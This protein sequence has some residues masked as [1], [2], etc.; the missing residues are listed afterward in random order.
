MNANDNFEKQK[1]ESSSIEDI[2]NIDNFSLDFSIPVNN[3]SKR[4][5]FEK[6]KTY[7][8]NVSIESERNYNAVYFKSNIVKFSKYIIKK[9]SKRRYI[10]TALLGICIAIITVFLT[11]NSGLYSAGFSGLFQGIARFVQ[12]IMFKTGSNPTNINLVYNLMF[13]GLYFVAN[14]PL[15]IFSYKKIS[16]EFT[17]LTLIYI[18]FN[19]ITGFTFN[20]I[21]HIGEVF[22][23]GD[24]TG[25][26]TNSMFSIKL[27]L[28][29]GFQPFLLL[30]YSIVGAICISLPYTL[31]YIFSGSTGGSDIISIYYAKKKNKNIGSM[32]IIVN[33]VCILLATILG[34]FGAQAIYD[35]N[36][37]VGV[38]ADIS[39]STASSHIIQALFSPNLI[40]SIINTIIV[41]TVVNYFFPR[42]KFVQVKVFAPN[43]QEMKQ[44]IIDAGYKH[45]IYINQSTNAM[46][47]ENFEIIETICMYI[48]LPNLLVMIRN[49]DKTSIISINRLS[50]IDGELLVLK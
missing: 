14:I 8:N 1:Y 23:F 3:Q 9:N 41:G 49:I 43:V 4:N 40:F 12:A 44:K 16:K 46:S 2:S 45:D 32:L 47:N 10:Y 36:G 15:F 34:S 39:N 17:Y 27:T 37:I 25:I 33:L 31:I 18:V 38:S 30:I 24:T 26:T 28:W 21:P 50:D 7:L 19:Q 42:T 29:N 22:I 13:W 11:Q 5:S 48:E 35:W 6:L 20:Q